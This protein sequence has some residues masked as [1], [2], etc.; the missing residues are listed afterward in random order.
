MVSIPIVA[1]YAVYRIKFQSQ[2]HFGLMG[3]PDLHQSWNPRHHLGAEI[4]G[5]ILFGLHILGSWV[6]ICPSKVGYNGAGDDKRDFE[7]RN[8]HDRTPLVTFGCSFISDR[9]VGA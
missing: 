1:Q 7:K 8:G 5:S 6:R 3:Y 4:T 9:V 2:D